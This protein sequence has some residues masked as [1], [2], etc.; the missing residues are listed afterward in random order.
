VQPEE[1]RAR[2]EGAPNAGAANG[3][4]TDGLHGRR[5]MGAAAGGR[6]TCRSNFRRR[7]R[8]VTPNSQR[9]RYAR[10]RIGPAQAP[11]SASQ[12]SVSMAAW[13]PMPAAVIAWR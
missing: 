3:H 12:R 10:R 1:Q 4:G 6:Q 2:N 8:I 9:I 7:R 13:Q 5:M 11:C